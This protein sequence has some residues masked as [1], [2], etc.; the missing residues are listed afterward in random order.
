MNN[1]SH[2]IPYFLTF[3]QVKELGGKVKKGTTAEM[4]I[5]FNVYYKDSNDMTISKEEALERRIVVMKFRY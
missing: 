4:V 1:T 2:S 5:Y 3:N